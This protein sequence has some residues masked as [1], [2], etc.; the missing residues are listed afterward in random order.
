[1]LVVY[2]FKILIKSALA[3][4]SVVTN[5]GLNEHGLQ[6]RASGEAKGLQ[7]GLHMSFR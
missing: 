6:I 7:V 2:Y 4:A 5:D 3:G 1:M